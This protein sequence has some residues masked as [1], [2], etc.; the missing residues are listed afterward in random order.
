NWADHEE[1]DH[2]SSLHMIPLLRV[3]KGRSF[4]LSFF[5]VARMSDQ[6]V[7]PTNWLPNQT[8]CPTRLAARPNWYK[9]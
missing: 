3:Q 9:G 5:V 1:R 6:T 7:C 2:G 4:D 8:G